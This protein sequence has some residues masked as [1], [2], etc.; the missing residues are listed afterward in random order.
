[1]NKIPDSWILDLPDSWSEMKET[2]PL[3]LPEIIALCEKM[4]PIWN[5][6]RFSKPPPPPLAE[7]FTLFPSPKTIAKGGESER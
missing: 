5:A 7:P 6:E 3:S 2:P 4:L 1:V